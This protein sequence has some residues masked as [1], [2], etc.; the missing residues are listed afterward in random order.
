MS[1]NKDRSFRQSNSYKHVLNY[2]TSIFWQRIEAGL[3]L[4]EI[5]GETS[6]S[7]SKSGDKCTKCSKHTF[8]DCAT[9]DII[10]SECSTSPL[11][12][13]NIHI[14]EVRGDIELPAKIITVKL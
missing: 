13:F 11:Q 14:N 5:D 1:C 8:L 9:R 4:P 3:P 10:R 2:I 6:L 7:S 12:L